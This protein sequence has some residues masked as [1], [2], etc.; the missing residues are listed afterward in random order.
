MFFWNICFRSNCAGTFVQQHQGNLLL[1]FFP[2]PSFYT[3]NKAH[4]YPFMML[5]LLDQNN[6]TCFLQAIIWIPRPIIPKE[7]LN[8]V[9]MLI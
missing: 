5:L 8:W 6:K 3:L 9:L 7:S 2:V 4:D 1:F